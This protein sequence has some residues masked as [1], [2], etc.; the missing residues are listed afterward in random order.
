MPAE[1]SLSARYRALFTE[2]NRR[3]FADRLPHYRIE[4]CASITRIGEHGRIYRRRRLIKILKT[5]EPEM[6]ATL[7]HEMVHAATYDSH[8]PRW[9]AELERVREAGAPLR[10]CDLAPAPSFTKGLAQEAAED[11][12]WHAPPV[13]FRQFV[14]VLALDNR[15]PMAFLLR[16]YPWM[17]N[18]FRAA[19][20]KVKE[21]RALRARFFPEGEEADR[22]K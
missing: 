17:Q 16:K 7:L 15:V 21:E 2:F 14:H 10:D 6:V 12:L 3:Y 5:T 4:V 19:K 13:T 18:V 9:R 22:K 1:A 11:L 20:Q 8:G